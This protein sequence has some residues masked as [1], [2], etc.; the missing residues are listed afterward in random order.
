MARF[1]YMMGGGTS[2]GYHV[3][4]FSNTPKTGIAG[5]GE[6]SSNR[7]SELGSAEVMPPGNKYHFAKESVIY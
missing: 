1:M 5:P 3:F 7:K 2:T 4:I 6:G